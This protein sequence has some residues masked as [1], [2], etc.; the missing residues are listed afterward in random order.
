M[1]KILD[2]I[3]ERVI[4]DL[5]NEE[6]NSPLWTQYKPVLSQ[7]YTNQQQPQQQPPQQPQQ[8][9]QQQSQQQPH[10]PPM[11]GNKVALVGD[12]YAAGMKPYW[13]LGAVYAY[14]GKKW[15]I[16]SNAVK[17]AANDGYRN[18]VV[19]CGVNGCTS[20]DRSWQ[21]EGVIKCCKNAPNATLWFFQYAKQKKQR[22]KGKY[23]DPNPNFEQIIRDRVLTGIRDGV[24][25][26]K[27]ARF[28]DLTDI[29]D[30]PLNLGVE[31]NG[32]YSHSGMHLTTQGYKMLAND[33]MSI[34]RGGG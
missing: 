3:V 15:D 31:K 9:S 23:G 2:Y 12:S 22:Q 24:S 1:T 32:Y 10:Y 27:N 30:Y 5:I 34:I 33:V 19:W 13:K 11:K 16:I 20:N 17:Q 14:P 26:C 8:Q 7:E 6:D 21:A 25:R 29:R 4:R 28:T 18:I